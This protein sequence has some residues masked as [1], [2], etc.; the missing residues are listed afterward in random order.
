MSQTREQSATSMKIKSYFSSSVEKAI[1][2]ARQEM[3]PEAMLLTTRRSPRGS[4][5]QG[6]YEVVFGLPASSAGPLSSAPAVDLSA[7]LQGLQ[8][9]LAEVKNALQLNGGKQQGSA[10]ILTEELGRE[11]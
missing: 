4:R 3:G 11:L 5:H 1:Q 10:A 9:Q 2:E 6:A 7:E 8:A